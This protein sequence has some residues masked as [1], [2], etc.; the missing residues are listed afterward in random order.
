MK[1]REAFVAKYGD[2]EK[3]AKTSCLKDLVIT[4]VK[5][6]A[7]FSGWQKPNGDHLKPE[8]IRTLTMNVSILNEIM[9]DGLTLHKALGN[10]RSP[11]EAWRDMAKSV[12]ELKKYD[13]YRHTLPENYRRL[14]DRLESYRANG[15]RD[16]SSTPTRGT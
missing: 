10:F 4:D 7:F 15:Y 6:E 1:Y 8:Q 5:A 2:P 9:T 14:R 13:R 3:M 11:S 16:F 12:K